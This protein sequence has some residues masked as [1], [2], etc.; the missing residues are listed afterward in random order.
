L[1]PT[2][3]PEGERDTIIKQA[4]AIINSV[5]FRYQG[6]ISAEHG[7]GRE[8]MDDF[9]LGLAPTQVQ[10]LAALKSAID[11]DWQMNPGVLF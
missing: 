8:K 1:P 5:L 10:L 2:G 7:I 11:P 6:S 9:R 3:T 4:K